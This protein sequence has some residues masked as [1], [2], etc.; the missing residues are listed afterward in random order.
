MYD[1]SDNLNTLDDAPPPEESGNKT[2]LLGAA[3]LGGIVL[4]SIVLPGRLWLVLPAQADGRAQC[5]TVHARGA[6]PAGE[7]GA[8]GQGVD[9][10]SPVHR[11]T[12]THQHAGLPAV[13]C[14]A[15][16]FPGPDRKS[17]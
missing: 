12:G 14:H 17:V 1:E 8:D 7:P 16:F 6:E 11:H 3:V 2:F 15:R 9:E 5:F 10:S 4:L 13:H